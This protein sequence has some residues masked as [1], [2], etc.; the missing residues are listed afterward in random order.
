M[1]KKIKEIFFG[2]KAAPVDKFVDGFT[3]LVPTNQPPEDEWMK[4]FRVSILFD[5]KIVHI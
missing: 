2:V 1:I 3:T 4:E 5:K